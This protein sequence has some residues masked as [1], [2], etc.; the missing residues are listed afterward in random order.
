MWFILG[1]LIGVTIGAFVTL[2]L[3]MDYDYED[4][5]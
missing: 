1:L 2:I 5:D 4:E 3:V